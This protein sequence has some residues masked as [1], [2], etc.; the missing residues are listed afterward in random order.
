MIIAP[1]SSTSAT[2][3]KVSPATSVIIGSSAVVSLPR[4]KALITIS[5]SQAPSTCAKM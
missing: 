5:P 1:I 2:A 4:R 3:Q